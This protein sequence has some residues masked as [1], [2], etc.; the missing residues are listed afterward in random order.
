MPSVVTLESWLV[1]RLERTTA[2]PVGFDECSARAHNDDFS[3][4]S[5]WC[6]SVPGGRGASSPK[7]TKT[8][9]RKA[10]KRGG[11]SGGQHDSPTLTRNGRI[12][13]AGSKKRGKEGFQSCGS[14]GRR[15]RV[16]IY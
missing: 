14:G 6:G 16:P 3:T 2:L 12:L 4:S 15:T 5:P 13:D 11:L 9:G 10:E 7:D 1:G 8:T